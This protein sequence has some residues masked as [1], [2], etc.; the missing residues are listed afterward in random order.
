[1][2]ARPAPPMDL[3]GDNGPPAWEISY[4]DGRPILDV[5][6]P[7]PPNDIYGYGSKVREWHEDGMDWY[8]PIRV[9]AAKVRWTLSPRKL[10]FVSVLLPGEP[11][12]AAAWLAWRGH[13]LVPTTER[14]ALAWGTIADT[15]SLPPLHGNEGQ[16]RWATLLREEY[17][18]LYPGKDVPRNDD[19]DWWLRRRHSLGV[20]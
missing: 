15:S 17:A 5:M 10:V 18:R 3:F 20:G 4:A 14:E 13:R 1:M 19:A 2:D 6:D 7:L 16:V 9:D 8:E 12:S 11:E